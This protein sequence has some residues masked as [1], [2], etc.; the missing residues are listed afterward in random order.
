MAT[1]SHSISSMATRSLVHAPAL[2][3]LCLLFRFVEC[4]KFLPDGFGSLFVERLI[5][6]GE[7]AAVHQFLLHVFG[8]HIEFFCEV[9]YGKTFGQCDLAEFTNRFR[10]GLR[11]DKRRVESLLALPFVAL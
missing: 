5:D 2:G 1:I 9:F 7:N 8:Q 6:G 11:T 3:V 10:L 4:H